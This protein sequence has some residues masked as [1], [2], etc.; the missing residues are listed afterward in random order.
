MTP[1][2]HARLWSGPRLRGRDHIRRALVVVLAATAGLWAAGAGAVP[3][4]AQGGA[5]ADPDG[6]TVVV[7]FQSLGA[8]TI[9]ACA[10]GPVSSGFDALGQAGIGYQTVTAFPGFICRIQGLPGDTDCADTPP[11]NAYWSY[12]TAERGGSWTYSQVG[13]G[14]RTPPAG[15]VEGWSFSTD[16]TSSDSTPP[17]TAPPAPAP[18]AAPTPTPT[19]TPSATAAPPPEPPAADPQPEEPTG[20]GTTAGAGQGPTSDIGQPAATEAAPRPTA[21]GP[22]DPRPTTPE[23]VAQATPAPPATTATPAPTASTTDG[24]TPSAAPTASPTATAGPQDDPSL[25]PDAAAVPSPTPPAN[26]ALAVDTDEEGVPA[27]LIVGGGLAAALA[28]AAVVVV[29]RREDV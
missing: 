16:A 7:D 14:S 6:V 1:H 29:R 28:G 8:G 26:S 13:A 12:W 21:S 27:G 11:A 17:R 15:S 22:A 18:E 5:C 20:E 10:P 24:P 2:P 25:D 4:D 9:V 23:Q 3:A 19:P